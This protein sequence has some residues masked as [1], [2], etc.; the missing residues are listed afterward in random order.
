MNIQL[1]KM[2]DKMKDQK[3]KSK[4]YAFD[5]LWEGYMTGVIF[6]IFILGAF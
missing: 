2:E 6:T 4:W 1:N 3:N 5:D